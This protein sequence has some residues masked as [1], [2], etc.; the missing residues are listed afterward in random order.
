MASRPKLVIA[1]PES[2]SLYP[3]K[4]GADKAELLRKI[5][6]GGAGQPTFI[7]EAKLILGYE[8]A[9]GTCQR[10]FKHYKDA[11]T[12]SPADL[13]VEAGGDVGNLEILKRIIQRGYANSHNWKP[14][15]KD[16]LDAMRLMVQI[17]GNTG[18]DELLSLFDVPD[19]AA[20]A[21]EDPAAVLSE[22]ERPTD[23]SEDLAEPLL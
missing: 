1:C 7:R 21:V 9:G 15:I 17:T 16:T 4:I 20:D 10:H 13:P 6:E 23:D 8:I 19:D 22:A 14:T 3:D 11:E 2:C 5:R 18:D 12:T